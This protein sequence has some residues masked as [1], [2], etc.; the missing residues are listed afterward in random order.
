[1]KTIKFKKI[2]RLDELIGY[3]YDNEIKEELK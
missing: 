1:M 2:M 3:I